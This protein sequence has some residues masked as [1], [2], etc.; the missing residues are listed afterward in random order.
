MRK[1]V[2]LVKYGCGKAAMLTDT[3]ELIKAIMEFKHQYMKG[4]PDTKMYGMP[5]I[6]KAELL[7]IMYDSIYGDKENEND[8][9]R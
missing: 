6:I 7:P 3:P 2:L 5:E 1:F 9:E 4:M 8:T